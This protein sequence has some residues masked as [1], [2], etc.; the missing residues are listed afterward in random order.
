[1]V[2][3]SVGEEHIDGARLERPQRR[4]ELRGRLR[5]RELESSMTSLFIV[6]PGASKYGN[7]LRSNRQIV[8]EISCRIQPPLGLNFAEPLNDAIV[9]SRNDENI[10]ELSFLGLEEFLELA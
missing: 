3:S 8:L 4:E 9:I 1:M 7:I 2:T 10:F 6:A 5:V